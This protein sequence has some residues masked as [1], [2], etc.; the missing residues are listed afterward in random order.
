M[1]PKI[2]MTDSYDKHDE[3]I[4]ELTEVEL[5]EILADD[6][7]ENE[8]EYEEIRSPHFSTPKP[9]FKV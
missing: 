3:D 6:D 8:G 5:K 2:K 4:I 1:S 7:F 9:Y